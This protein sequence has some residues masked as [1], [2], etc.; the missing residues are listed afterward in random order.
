MRAGTGN[1]T[2]GGSGGDHG[3]GAPGVQGCCT[4][5]ARLRFV[6]T[7]TLLLPPEQPLW[8]VAGGRPGGWTLQRL[9]GGPAALACSVA[10]RSRILVAVPGT[11]AAKARGGASTDV[12]GGDAQMPAAGT[13]AQ[14]GSA[15]QPLTNHG[16]AEVLDALEAGAAASAVGLSPP[17]HG[18]FHQGAMQLLL[19]SL[20]VAWGSPALQLAQK[21]WPPSQE[22]PSPHPPHATQPPVALHR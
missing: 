19:Y 21:A 17:P 10:S 1:T 22:P 20:P 7:L 11:S 13:A 8:A 16:S 14:R 4:S 3:D 2:L 18:G 5:A 6:Q 12:A 15:P 9:F